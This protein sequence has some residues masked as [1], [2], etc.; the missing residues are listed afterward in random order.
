MIEILVKES[1]YLE[2][3]NKDVIRKIKDDLTINNPDHI[4]R[5]RLKKW[6]GNTPKFLNLY[7][8]DENIYIL[9]F[10]YLSR[11]EQF[12]I[13]SNIKYSIN[14]KN[15]SVPLKINKTEIGRAHV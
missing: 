7:E 9:P 1:L 4:K 12:L 15:A 2:T 14:N 10:G 5:L 6:L 8:V 3:T 11:L 13:Q